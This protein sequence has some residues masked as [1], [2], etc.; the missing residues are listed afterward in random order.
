[1]REAFATSTGVLLDDE[2]WAGAQLSVRLGGIGLRSGAVH[3]C[4]GYVGS[5]AGSL[6]LAS[7]IDGGFDPDA[8]HFAADVLPTLQELNGKLPPDKHVTAVTPDAP[9]QRELSESIDSAKL[10][11]MLISDATPVHVRA[12]LRL[13]S[14][15]GAGAWLNVAPA[16]EDD[17]EMTGQLFRVA[18]KRRVRAPLLE[19]EAPCPCCGLAMD[20]WMDHALVCSCNGDR[21]LRHNAVRN[22]VYWLAAVSGLLP[23]KE[24]P[25]LLPLRPEAEKLRGEQ[26][27]NNNRRPADVWVP[28]WGS[29]G[30]AAWDFAVTSA[31]RSDNMFTAANEPSAAAA[32]YE[33]HKRDHLSTAQQCGEQG[34]QFMPLVA[35]AHSGTWG[36]TARAVWHFLAKSWAAASGSD[37]SLTS[38]KLAQRLST[39]LQRAN[40]R[41][42]LRRM[43]SA[44]PAPSTANADAWMEGDGV[45]EFD[46]D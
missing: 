19:R 9:R 18:V 11:S 24:K 46:G 33:W 5:L 21:T 45:S 13:V 34:L 30:P 31:L 14:Q 26:V 42:V 40:A 25:G 35:E 36:P 41:A 1:M 43:V 4:A 8:E 10:E 3:A 44:G 15:D 38:A 37:V 22:L 6:E 20:V 32:T 12:H 27:S 17:T 16:A 7:K 29:G 28:Q 39:T 2:A 23:E